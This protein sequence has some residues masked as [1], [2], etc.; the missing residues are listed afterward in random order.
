MKKIRLDVYLA[1]NNLSRSRES[2]KKEIISGWVTINGETIREPSKKIEG[3][4]AIAVSRPKGLFVSRGGEKLDFALK[5]FKIS[6]QGK[7]AADLG[8]STGGFT[9][10]M[11]KAGAKLVYAIDVGYGQLDYALRKD[12]RVIVRER[13]NVRDLTPEDFDHRVDFV[14]ADLSFI[15]I[16]KVF[17]TIKELFTPST[18]IILLKPQFEAQ[19]NEHKKG[20]VR[21]RDAHKSIICRVV[22]VLIEKGMNF[23]G[24]CPSPIKGPAGNIEFLIYFSLADRDEEKLFFDEQLINDMVE[25]AHRELMRPLR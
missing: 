17:D 23:R 8:A 18:G 12:P 19:R 9:D 6:L 14:T 3:D 7:T 5:K 4:E 25:D 16:V 20:V 15:S 10:C 22:P 24:I 1:E 13:T 11:L 21:K 2:A